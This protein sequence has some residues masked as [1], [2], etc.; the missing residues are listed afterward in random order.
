MDVE[1]EFWRLCD[2][3]TRLDDQEDA[4]AAERAMVAMI[5]L[6]E[7]HP[8][9]RATFVRCFSDLVLWKRRTPNL[10]VAFCMRRLRFPEIPELI[11]RDA[12]SHKGTAYYAHHMNYWSEI[13][14]AYLDEIWEC[15]NLF[16]FYRN[17]AR[18]R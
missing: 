14:H 9:H 10:R 3:A 13:N 18:E 11:H 6:V 1:A 12:D 5:R 2:E 15:A 16:D 4:R 17:E 7:E 8:E